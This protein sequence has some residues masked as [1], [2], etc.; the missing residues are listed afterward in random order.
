MATTGVQELIHE[1][2]PAAQVGSKVPGGSTTSEGPLAWAQCSG[3]T[4]ERRG[5]IA[6]GRSWLA[7][8]T[9]CSATQAQISESVSPKECLTA[10]RS[11]G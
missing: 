7:V 11:T 1:I 10:G 8:S 4:L 2:K 9:H 6:G 5:I 3:M